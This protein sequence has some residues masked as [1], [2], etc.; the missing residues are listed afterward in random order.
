MRFCDNNSYYNLGYA[1]GIDYASTGTI[2]YNYH[3]HVDGNGKVQSEDHKS[4]EAGGCFT[5]PYYYYTYQYK[6]VDDAG[7]VYYTTEYIWTTTEYTYNFVLLDTKYI[8][9]CGKTT[10]TIDSATITFN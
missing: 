6:H 4:T 3:T 7:N 9:G 5:I 10:D 8:L 1:N 2:E